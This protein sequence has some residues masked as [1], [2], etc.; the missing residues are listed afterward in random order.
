MPPTF[1][2]WQAYVVAAEV[3][4]ATQAST[5][6]LAALRAQRIASLLA[7]AA[8]HSPRYRRLLAG[9]DPATVR[10]EDLPV[11]HKA[12]LMHDFE[13]WVCEPALSLR[14]LR[15]FV[16]DPANIAAECLGRYTVWES[17]GS[18]GEPA[19]FVQDAQAMAVYDAL[20]AL[21][22]PLLRPLDRLLDPWSMAER[23]AFVGATDGH[24]ASTVS[25]ERLRHLQPGLSERLRGISFL[26]PLDKLCA[27]LDAFAPTVIATYPS[28]AVL[29]AEERRAGRLKAVPR[30]IWTGGET[31]SAASRAFVHKAFA[32][33]VANSY[34]ASEFLSLAFECPLGVLHLNSDWAILEPVDAHGRAVPLGQAGTTTLLTNLANHLQPLIRYDLG[35]R[36]TLLEAACKCGSHLQ[37]I[38]VQ[39]RDDDTLR[40]AGAA[41]GPAISVVPLAV[42]TV[43]EEEAG[44]FDFQLVQQGPHDLLLKTRG[45]GAQAGRTLHKARTVLAAFLEAQGAR[46]IHIHCHGGESAHCGRSGKTRR[47]ISQVDDERQ[48]C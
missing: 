10:L 3:S 13:G 41:G 15:R 4:M 33:P 31:L 7:A 19:I 1:D 29:L 45:Q 48:A 12:E 17:S 37:A 14:T 5:E 8:A 24:F 32:C 18:T 44:L 40:L 25:V 28:A 11:S 27:E 26:Q 35:D 9:R 20:E 36:V 2:P 30:E 22:R 39:G 46:G 34:G 23:I 16:A 21:R 42:S 47:V 6:S 43:L 38:E